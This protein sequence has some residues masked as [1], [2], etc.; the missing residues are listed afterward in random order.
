MNL[1]CVCEPDIRCSHIV[2][3]YTQSNS[4]SRLQAWSRW[5]RPS[6]DH[7]AHRTLASATAAAPAAFNIAIQMSRKILYT[8]FVVILLVS[9]KSSFCF[10]F[11]LYRF[12]PLPHYAIKSRRK[13]KKMKEMKSCKR[14]RRKIILRWLSR[15]ACWSEHTA[16]Q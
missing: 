9:L 1:V 13:R 8:C 4:V 16:E 11:R 10:S 15:E 6:V 14:M 12:L 5:L 3:L 2:V 7:F